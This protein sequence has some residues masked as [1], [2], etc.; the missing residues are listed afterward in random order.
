MKNRK[1]AFTLI[2]LLIVIAIIATL[3]AILFPVLAQ[4]RRRSYQSACLS[5]LHQ[6]GTGILL[7]SHDY[8]DFLPWASGLSENDPK[9]PKLKI[10]LDPYIKSSKVWHCPADIGVQG[11][12]VDVPISEATSHEV[13]GS[14][15]WQWTQL[16]RARRP[17]SSFQGQI[18]AGEYVTVK[19]DVPVSPSNIIFLFD[20]D[21]KWHQGRRNSWFLD[22]HAASVTE[23][24]VSD[25]FWGYIRFQGK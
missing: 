16:I 5:N 13:Y 10:V 11:G 25:L 6:I 2:E 24:Y 9:I 7:Y 1:K 23:H 19:T 21:D 18:N 22:G 8:D 12:M 17:L 14:S 20:G 3:A 4:M 15:Y